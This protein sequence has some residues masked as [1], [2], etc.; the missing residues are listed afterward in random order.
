MTI[1]TYSE[2]VTELESYLNRADYTPRIPTFIALTEARLN[3]LLDDPEM[4]VRATATGTGQFTTLPTDFKRLVGI[5]VGGPY[6]NLE[7]ISGSRITSLDQSVAGDPR[8]YAIVDGSITFAPIDNAANMTMLYVRRIP[9]LTSG[10][11]SNWL[12]TLAP[13]LYLYGALVQANIFGW[14]DDRVAGFKAMFDEA[15]E[16]LRRDADN[17]RWGSAPLAPRL[18]RT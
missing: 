14:Q 13:D 2:L 12:L 1:A 5:S 15:I 18:G 11:P 4:E 10:A 7:Q 16:E 6:Y 3:R 8:Y 17:R 9:A